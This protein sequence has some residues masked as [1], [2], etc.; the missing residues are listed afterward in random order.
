MSSDGVPLPTETP[1]CRK[2]TEGEA[3]NSRFPSSAEGKQGLRE[4]RVVSRTVCAPSSSLPYLKREE[5]LE[6]ERETNVCGLRG[7]GQDKSP[8]DRKGVSDLLTLGWKVGFFGTGPS[9]LHWAHYSHTV[10]GRYTSL[11]RFHIIHERLPKR[12]TVP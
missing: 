4:S 2:R 12:E 8:Y 9:L 3:W 6:N 7:K 11:N 1:G 10:R 5:T